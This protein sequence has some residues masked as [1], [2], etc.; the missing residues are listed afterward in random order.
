M[1]LPASVLGTLRVGLGATALLGGCD[2]SEPEVLE[3]GFS[4][5]VEVETP[6]GLGQEVAML[7]DQAAAKEVVIAASPV[8]GEL[9][10]SRPRIRK[11]VRE[12]DRVVDWSVDPCPP[13]GRG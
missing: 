11:R 9:I 8:V 3:P 10:E 12:L 5:A 7:V 13:C 6:R 4:L 2:A 1:R